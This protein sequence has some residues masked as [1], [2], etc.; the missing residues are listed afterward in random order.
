[1]TMAGFPAGSGGEALGEWAG[2]GDGSG[3]VGGLPIPGQE[4]GNAAVPD[5]RR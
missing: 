5:A 4:F 3:G 1:M 2:L